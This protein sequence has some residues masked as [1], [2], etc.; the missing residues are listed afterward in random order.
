VFGFLVHGSCVVVEFDVASVVLVCE[1]QA[2]LVETVGDCA[3]C[4][5]EKGE[6]K[7]E[8]QLGFFDGIGGHIFDANYNSV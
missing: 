6:N 8:G 5:G 4:Y 2:V 3:D 1:V 7:V